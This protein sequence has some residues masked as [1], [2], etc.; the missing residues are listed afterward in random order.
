ML[1][2][3]DGSS[4][5]EERLE[6]EWVWWI[7]GC[8]HHAFYKAIGQRKTCNQGEEGISGGTSMMSVT[9]DRNEEGEAMGCSHFWRRS[10]GGVE[11]APWYRWRTTK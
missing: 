4:C 5:E 11:V 7:M 10:G 1:R 8:S 3:G 9:R 6:L 2:W